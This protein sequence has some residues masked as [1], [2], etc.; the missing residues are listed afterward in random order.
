MAYRNVGKDVLGL[1]PHEQKAPK[2]SRRHYEVIARALGHG[3]QTKNMDELT[4]YFAGILQADN[5]RFNKA[6]FY[7]AVDKAE[8][9]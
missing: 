8:K 7:K 4:G 1:N 2:F 5:P 9:E 6:R 3:K